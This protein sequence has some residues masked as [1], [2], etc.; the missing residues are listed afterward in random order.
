MGWCNATEIFDPMVRMI[1]DLDVPEEKQVEVIA[2]LIELLRDGDWDCESDS[3][4]YKE[5]ATVRK[6]FLSLDE[7]EY[8]DEDDD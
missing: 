3:D 5:N 7:H 6:A 4:F 1:I 8:D 2:K